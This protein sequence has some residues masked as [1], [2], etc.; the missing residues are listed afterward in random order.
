MYQHLGS[1][2]SVGLAIISI[3][4]LAG[5]AL[6]RTNLV[7]LRES[8]ADA[9]GE[10]DDKDRRLKGIEADRDRIKT[11]LAALTRVVTGE[12]HW[13]AIGRKLDNHHREAMAHWRTDEDT[14]MNILRALES[15]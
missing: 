15:T 9:R 6:M 4:T 3:A 2:L 8:L 5:L 13:V 14:L 11:D 1:L 12:A 7:T 10:I